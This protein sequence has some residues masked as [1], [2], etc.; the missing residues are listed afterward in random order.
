MFELLAHVFDASDWDEVIF[1][2][3]GNQITM[4]KRPAGR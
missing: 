4:I 1:S 2:E 3:R